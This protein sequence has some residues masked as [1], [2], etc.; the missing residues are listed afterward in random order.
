ME[1]NFIKTAFFDNLDLPKDILFDIP[2]ITV[3]G[4]NE[5]TVDNYKNIR[6]FSD[7][8]ITVNTKSSKII[9]TGTEISISCLTKETLIVKGCFKT[10][11]FG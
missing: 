5:L 2:V 6:D 7:K 11:E 10:L 4:K 1:H 3:T 8:Q 9:I